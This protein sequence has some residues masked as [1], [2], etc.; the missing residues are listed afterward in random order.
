M[1]LDVI[2]CFG[3]HARCHR[4][5]V[6]KAVQSVA[7]LPGALVEGCDVGVRVPA[8]ALLLRVRLREG[9][10]AAA[11]VERLAATSAAARGF[12]VALRGELAGVSSAV[13]DTLQS[14]DTLAVSVGSTELAGVVARALDAVWPRTRCAERPR[15]LRERATCAPPKAARRDSRRPRRRSPDALPPSSPAAAIS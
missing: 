13:A 1:S 3:V 14:S 10:A 9:A 12:A 4:T 15:R 11:I 7:G 5:A 6:A 8:R 2:M